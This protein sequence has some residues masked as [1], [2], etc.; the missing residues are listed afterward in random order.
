MD[1]Y[2]ET[3]VL[4]LKA[5]TPSCDRAKNVKMP[6]WMAQWPKWLPENSLQLED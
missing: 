1:D 3:P 5:Y 2:N 4:D 6:E